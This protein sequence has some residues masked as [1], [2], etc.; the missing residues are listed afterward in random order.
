MSSDETRTEFGEELWR[1]LEEHETAVKQSIVSVG[2]VESELKSVV[3]T[4]DDMEEE[5]ET[6]DLRPVIAGLGEAIESHEEWLEEVIRRL[7]DHKDVIRSADD[8][9]KEEMANVLQEARRKARQESRP[10][11]GGGPGGSAPPTDQYEPEADAHSP[12]GG[13]HSHEPSQ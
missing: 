13:E 4:L 2:E 3:E 5:N 8:M 1:S 11:G 10:P 9:G 12:N 6:S 7:N